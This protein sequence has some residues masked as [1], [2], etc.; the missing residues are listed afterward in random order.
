MTNPYV[1][2]EPLNGQEG[3][4]NRA[5]EI[6]R[7]SSRIAADRP[8][9]VSIVGQQRMGKTSL[10]NLLC[11]PAAQAEYL[12]DPAQYVILCLKLKEQPPDNPEAFFAHMETTLQACGL[13]GMK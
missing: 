9:S 8:Q 11:D 6:T 4:C 2:N 12:D 13:E 5:S 7:I 1:Y 10:L 3:F